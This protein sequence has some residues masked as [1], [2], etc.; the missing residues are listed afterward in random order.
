M[1]QIIE[2][3]DV[4]NKLNDELKQ[5][6]KILYVF[7]DN[8]N[9]KYN[10]LIVT[11]D[12]KTYAFGQNSND[13]LGFGHNRVVN[14]IQIVE[15]L[16][17]QQ[18]IDFANGLRHCIARNS[19]GKIYCWSRNYWK[20]LGNGF[21]KPKLNK[22][23]NN[24]FVFDISC[25]EFHTLVLT[26]CGEVYAWGENYSGQIGNGCNGDQLI[27][28]KVK[29]FK[30]ERVVMISC[31]SRHSMALTECGHVYSWG[32]NNFGQLGIGNTVKSYEPKFVAV[33]DESK[34]NVFI[35]KI[36]CG[37][38]HSLLLSSDGNIYA[39][40][41]NKFGAL[42][43]QNEENELRP[44]R[45]KIETKFIDISSRWNREISIALSHDGIHYIWG[46][47]GEEIIRTPKATDL[48]SFAE[49]YAK[50]FKTTHKVIN[51]ED[52]NSVPILLRDKY[53]N[54]KRQNSK[55]SQ[56]MEKIDVL[57]T[58][59][60]GF[61][62][63]VKVL[64]VFEDCDYFGD[65]KGF[66]VLIVTK[67]DKTYAFGVNSRGRLGFGHNRV[68]NE[69][70]IVKELCDQQIIDFSNGKYH[71]IARNSSGKVYCWGYNEFGY[72]GIGSKDYSSYKPILNQYLNNEFVI[73]ISCG[74]S[75]SLVLTNCGE[76]YAW[77][78]NYSGQI[79]NDCN[80]HQLMP[81]KVKG[82][83]NERVVMISCGWRH[84]MALTECGHV[85]SWGSNN[86]GQLGI[87]NTVD[88]NEP[89]FVTVIDEN[90]CIVFIEKIS[91]GSYHSLLLSSDGYIY[92]F[93]RNKSG[94]SGNQNEENELSPQRIKIETKFIDISS[95]WNNDISIA[96][97]Q[98]GIYY[99]WGKCGEEIIR[100]PKQTD[101]ESF[102]EIY[103]KYL[104]ITNKAINFEDQNSVPIL[105]RDKY[106]NEFSEQILIS[107]GGFGIV[108][109]V[110]H[111][112]SKKTYAIKRI[113]LNKVESE[114]TFKELN[115][116]KGLKSRYVVEH[117]DSWIEEN[118][119]KFEDFK[120]THSASDMSSSHPI[121]DPKNNVLL[122]IQKE[123][124][125]QSLNDV[126]KQLSNE[127]RENA[128]KTMKTLCYY[129]CCELLTEIIEC[130]NYLH[131]RNVI[132]M[133]LKPKNILLTNGINGRFVKLGNFGLSLNH[134][135]YN[136]S[137]T[138]RSG[139]HKYMAPE[140]LISRECDMKADIYSL[141]IIVREL[142]FLKNNS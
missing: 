89:K 58:L 20:H 7:E 26:N 18:I 95:R 129:I 16:C 96:L 132:H 37:Y 23:L 34:R 5:S 82:F 138:H 57:N 113:A 103:A 139:T 107:C 69:I 27:P 44:Q 24:E 65:V 101:F 63:R 114:K 36:S 120:G 45:I 80:D 87:G 50:Y 22:Y 125:S 134:E 47:C 54:D 64:Y 141:G 112:I 42:G 8:Y 46:Q 59:N 3:L 72:L 11:K 123:F 93:G 25:G 19:S 66:N 74:D 79:G 6:V 39:F 67:D 119:M 43:N 12:D 52:Q 48:K 51:F 14:E 136:E 70:Q 98:D 135:F 137:Q 32:E 60:Y 49:I 38:C 92:A 75:H 85:Y 131:E 121:F 122:H 21:H 118:A 55:M 130:L 73:D 76:V 62:Q 1:S 9:N 4:L 56:I 31:G 140:V 88:S 77:G 33:I 15:E 99:I 111:K 35:E 90:K 61:K 110:M 86:C 83:N 126:I 91:C 2:K 102:V 81:I 40:G 17:D 105:L 108:S 106:V 28:I 10:V 133:N 71:C 41:R 127:L 29:G 97:S 104:K 109:K 53:V 30:N 100:T 117:I 115:L 128:S 142:F 84:S 13:Q 124:I 68:V 78:E 94:E 116:M